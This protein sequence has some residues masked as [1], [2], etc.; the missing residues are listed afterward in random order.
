MNG[1][2]NCD[3]FDKNSEY[4]PSQLTPLCMHMQSIKNKKSPKE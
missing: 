1:T 4:T 3:I 2:V